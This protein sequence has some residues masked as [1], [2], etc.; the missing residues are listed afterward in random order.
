V[1]FSHLA[2]LTHSLHSTILVTL[3]LQ[4]RATPRSPTA[5]QEMRKNILKEIAIDKA[6]RRLAREQ[7]AAA[8]P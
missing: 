3:I 8:S 4:L 5:Q 2:H 7:N 1:R 6:A